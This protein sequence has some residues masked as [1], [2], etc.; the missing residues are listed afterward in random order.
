MTPAEIIQMRKAEV[1]RMRANLEKD[2]ALRNLV[3]E[4]LESQQ[5]LVNGL[6]KVNISQIIDQAQQLQY[7]ILPSL[8]QKYGLQH[9]QYIYWKGVLDSL[10]WLLYVMDNTERLERKLIQVRHQLMYYK[11]L[12]AKLEKELQHFT[13]ME[14][15]MMKELIQKSL[16]ND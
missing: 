15:F 3:L 10:N 9:E 11:D 4:D 14:N 1:E 5:N 13:T 6:K 12:N 2:A 7:K 16:S 8:E